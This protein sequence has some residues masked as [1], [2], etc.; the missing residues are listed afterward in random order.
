MSVAEDIAFVGQ[1]LDAY[2]VDAYRMSIAMEA[3]NDLG[4]PPEMQ[5]GEVDD[6]GYVEWRVLQ[7]V[8]LYPA[9]A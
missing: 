7:S 3:N 4:I 8:G 2:A 6:E 5:V 9:K 1:L